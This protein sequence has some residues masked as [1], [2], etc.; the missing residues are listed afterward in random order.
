LIFKGVLENDGG[1]IV[2]H[3]SKKK[4]EKAGTGYKEVS[5]I[6]FAEFPRVERG[7]KFNKRKEGE[8]CGNNLVFSGKPE[9]MK[10]SRR[11]ER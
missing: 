10:M 8:K 1:G 5:P 9:R 4:R 3:L 2:S 6:N 11:E 7:E